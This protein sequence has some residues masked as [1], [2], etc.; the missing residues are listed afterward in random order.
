[1]RKLAQRGGVSE[2]G[3]HAKAVASDFNRLYDSDVSDLAIAEVAQP[4]IDAAVS[5]AVAG[6]NVDCLAAIDEKHLWQSRAR[7]AEA[8][9]EKAERELA[10][11]VIAV[12]ER[13]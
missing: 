7:N 12:R 3:K 2:P 8:R 10:Q 1:M 4:H 5:E 11:L 9:A 13:Q 6:L